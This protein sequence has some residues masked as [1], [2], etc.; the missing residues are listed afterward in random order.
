MDSKNVN[1][2]VE[3][4]VVEDNVEHVVDDEK[5]TDATLERF[6]IEM[7][8]A[9]EE[10]SNQCKDYSDRDLL[11]NMKQTQVITDSYV[12]LS[13]LLTLEKLQRDLK[14]KADFGLEEAEEDNNV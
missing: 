14:N 6:Q 11:I 7:E 10:V 2:I 8:K 12:K 13:K 5:K 4:E 9:V 1:E 3:N